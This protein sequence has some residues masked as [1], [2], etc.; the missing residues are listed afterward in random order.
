MLSPPFTLLASIKF[1]LDRERRKR[2]VRVN[3]LD[4]KRRVGGV[5]EGTGKTR[6]MKN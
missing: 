2:W 3:R 4:G 1:N 5:H 6:K